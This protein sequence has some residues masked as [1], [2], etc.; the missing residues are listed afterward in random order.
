MLRSLISISVH[1]DAFLTQSS[2]IHP[3]LLSHIYINA[4]FFLRR[5]WRIINNQL[6]KLIRKK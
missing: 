5:R 2:I 3:H 6:S 1:K 4:R